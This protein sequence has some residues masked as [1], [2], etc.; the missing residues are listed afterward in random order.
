MGRER[1]ESFHCLLFETIG[2]SRLL[3]CIMMGLTKNTLFW[4]GK[5][6]LGGYIVGGSLGDIV[7]GRKRIEHGLCWGERERKR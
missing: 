2:A 5:L 1:T 6:D 3:E 4:R 7:E